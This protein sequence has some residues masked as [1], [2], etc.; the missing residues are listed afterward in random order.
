[1]ARKLLIVANWKMNKTTDQTIDFARAVR[2]AELGKV[3]AVVCPPFTSIL[4]LS[5]E[6]R[7]CGIKVGAQNIFYEDSGTFTGE[8]SAPMIKDFCK[9]VIVGHSERRTVFGETDEVV[10]RKAKKAIEHGMRPIICVGETAEDRE[11]GR[12]D[13][14]IEKQLMGSLAGISGAEM[15][16]VELAY[17]PLWAI[18][19]GKGDTKTKAATPQDAEAVHMFIR[20]VLSGMHGRDVSEKTRILY[21][22][23]VKPENVAQ[24]TSTG[25]IDGGLV[26]GASLDPKSFRDLITNAQNRPWERQDE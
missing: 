15:S 11:Q 2:D 7:D 12:T 21:G 24:F 6:F 9:Y 17:E 25:N 14:V 5:R 13:E 20:K 19:K 3:E 23:S 1:M 4:L 8:V 18:S 26:G 10:N 22:G 16:K